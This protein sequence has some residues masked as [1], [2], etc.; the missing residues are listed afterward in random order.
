M[1]LRH[2]DYLRLVLDTGSFPAAAK[3]AGV[4]QPAISQAMQA[5]QRALGVPLFDRST[6]R[7]VPTRAAFE[8]VE[9]GSAFASKLEA[10][11]SPKPGRSSRVAA[12][13]G[14][15]V[16]MSA[17]A[18]LLFGPVIVQAWM[19]VSTRLSPV[20]IVN[21]DALEML[22]DLRAG[23][24]DFVVAPRPRSQSVRG[25][26]ETPLFSSQPTIYARKGHPLAAATTLAD[27][28]KVGW[29]VAGREGSGPGSMIEEAHRVRRLGISRVQAYCPN[30]AALLAMAAET[31]LMGVVPHPVLMPESLSDRLRPVRVVEG[32]PRYEVCLFRLDSA[33]LSAGAQ[34][35]IQNILA[36]APSLAD[37]PAR[38]VRSRP[39]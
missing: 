8:V 32:L 25:L 10:L 3:A 9:L 5:L 31:D 22:R 7:N 23:L 26:T 37:G 2:L 28:K 19:K 1:R 11:R 38:A 13:P 39:R 34:A 21:A 30:Y 12:K 29:I 16:G 17:G 15:T 20:K 27:L 6:G 18:A 14:L 24:F 36:T 33:P 4:S 35:V